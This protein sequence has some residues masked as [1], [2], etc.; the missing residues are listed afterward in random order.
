[1]RRAASSACPASRRTSSRWRGSNVSVMPAVALNPG[2]R[3]GDQLGGSG[4][5]GARQDHGEV[6]AAGA[7]TEIVRIRGC[8][9]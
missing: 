5:A 8:L 4:R 6:V 7:V 2:W 9:K 3:G 1:M